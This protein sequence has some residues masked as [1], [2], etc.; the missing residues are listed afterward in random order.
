VRRKIFSAVVACFLVCG[1]AVAEGGRQD[2]GINGCSVQ[3]LA[4][5]QSL[6]LTLVACDGPNGI[7]YSHNFGD[8]WTRSSGG[9]YTSGRANGVAATSFG[10]YA[11]VSDTELIRSD[12][13]T[14]GVFPSNWASVGLDVIGERFVTVTGLQSAGTMIIFAT[15]P[16]GVGASTVVRVLDSESGTYVG[17]QPLPVSG[18]LV[19][20]AVIGNFIFA[21]RRNSGDIDG[22]NSLYRASFDTVSGTIGAWQEITANVTGL[23]TGGFSS[24]F[25]DGVYGS[26]AATVFVR[27]TNPGSQ[28]RVY[29]SVD[30]GATFSLAFPNGVFDGNIQGDRYYA[31]GNF[32]RPCSQGSTVIINSFISKNDGAT[33]ARFKPF[34]SEGYNLFDEDVCLFQPDDATANTALIRTVEGLSKST[35]LQ[36]AEPTLAAANSGINGV[37]IK[38]A[39]RVRDGTS[40][41]VALVTNVGMAI[42]KNFS[43]NT[44]QWLFPTCNSQKSCWNKGVAVS[45]AQPNIVFSGTENMEIG[46]IST[47]GDGSLSVAWETMLDNPSGP[48]DG[49]DLP[50]NLLFRDFPE[51]PNRV[52]GL[53]AWEK[54]GTL[55]PTGGIY[56]I[57]YSSNLGD[58]TV[59]PYSVVLEGQPVV[60]LIALNSSVFYAA[61]NYSGTAVT[62]PGPKGVYKVVLA[63]DGSASVTADTSGDLG[64]SPGI[65]TFAYDKSR[66][67]LYGVTSSG[68]F[69]VLESAVAG[70]GS[71]RLAAAPGGVGVV[72]AVAVDG[73]SGAVFAAREGRVY[74]SEDTAGTWSEVFRGLLD[75]EFNVLFVPDED[76]PAPARAARATERALSASQLIGGSTVGLAKL[77]VTTPTSGSNQATCKLSVNRECRKVVSA[78]T[79]CTFTVTVR[80]AT[81]KAPITRQKVRVEHFRNG[82]WKKEKVITTGSQG[83]A[84]TRRMIPMSRKY[85]ARLFGSAYRC[86]SKP[87]QLRVR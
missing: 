62:P 64:A 38:G 51:V 53:Y 69:Y 16:T 68:S 8:T 43:S 26:A 25:I 21:V 19:H 23:L 33:W 29:R 73:A 34:I 52:F 31:P 80:R 7:Y 6:G 24:A 30:N 12:A 74:R 78:G 35:D 32:T 9:D 66:D 15:Q 14:P 54:A 49:E 86:T 55:E 87:V 39:S 63:G 75:E 41:T 85:R 81:T 47:A 28:K 70:T 82:A 77:A 59:T 57:G 76:I 2:L 40:D 1:I 37:V 61:V 72:S 45:A 42:T 48:T 17:A 84:T 11:L 22:P 4:H 27:V 46:R 50:V 60:D 18:D 36:A 58:T 79:Q 67:I 5:V 10:V 3:G 56:S 20:L 71:W 13:G 83:R 65:A 44:R